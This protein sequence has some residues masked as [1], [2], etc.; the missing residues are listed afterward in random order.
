[1]LTF[2]DQGVSSASN[3]IVGLAVARLAGP[4]EFGAYMLTYTLWLVIVGCHRSIVTEPIIVN[5][6]GR[7]D[8]ETLSHGVSAELLLGASV[9]AIALVGGLT[10]LA[11]GARVA[12][13]MLA[14][15]PWFAALLVQDYWRA[16]AF[17]QRRP[18]LALVNDSMFAA[19]QVLAAGTF[20]L[21]GWRSVGS[22]ITAWG[23]GA[24][25]GALLG[26]IWFPASARPRAG[27]QLVK[28]LWPLSRW[29]LAE[30]VTGFTADQA[31]LVLVA[32]LLSG[33]AYGG[34]RAGFNLM[35]PVLVILLAG[36]NVGLPEAAA[37]TKSDDP[38]D[39]PRYARRMSLLATAGIAAYGVVVAVAGGRLLRLL[40]G[41]QFGRY[42]LLATL[43]AVQY[44]IYALVFGQGIALKAAGRMRRLWRI[45][46]LIAVLSL[47]SVFAL[48][49]LLGTNGAGW[50]GVATAVYYTA[51]IWWLYHKELIQGGG[52]ASGGAGKRESATADAVTTAHV[53]AVE[54]VAGVRLRPEIVTYATIGAAAEAARAT[55]SAARAAGE[56]PAPLGA[57]RT[58]GNSVGRAAGS[59]QVRPSGGNSQS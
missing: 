57:A 55:R 12:T 52:G 32:G 28:R 49:R 21:I 37:R 31:Y 27:R 4:A 45:R 56:A 29:M 13:P 43:A 39:L 47:T 16:M 6:A 24:T 50:G 17:K 33:V 5:T 15:A 54:A 11:F 18:G 38:D 3:F 46:A 26:L 7:D 53:T 20:W 48:V 59:D 1:M 9:S 35:G 19:V 36:G 10:A 2:C 8:P 58:N 22:M 23:L 42:G 44:V 14:M 51:G 25:A 30:F 41:A 40:Y 34:F